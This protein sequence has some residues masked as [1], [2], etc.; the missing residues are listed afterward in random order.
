MFKK[1]LAEL[2]TS[3]PLRGS[4]RR[5][6]RQRVLQSYPNL[7]PEEGDALVPDGLQSQKF[8]THLDD[9]GVAYLSPDG[10]PLWFTIGKGSED[11]IP[12][13]YTLWKR[14]DLLPF[15]S[16]PAP[17]VPKLIGGADL[18]IPGVIQHS[19]TL[20]P[21]QVVS[22]TQ[23][24]RDAIG[25]P[26]AVGRMAVSSDTLRSE[27]EEDVKGK[28]VYILH[29]WK[30]ALWEMGPSK[31]ADPPAPIENKSSEAETPDERQ[32]GSPGSLEETAGAPP[33][34]PSPDGTSAQDA[35]PPA[36]ADAP[37][38]ADES[39]E[40]KATS[41]S[42]ED[43][44][45]CLR[46]AVLHTI[47]MRLANVPPSTFPIPASTFW[48]SHVLPARPAAA[49]GPNGLADA[50]WIDVKHSTH[51]NVKS[52]LKACAKEGLIKLKETKGDVVITAVSP[53]H[54]AVLAM[55]RHRTIGD[56]EA[57]AKKAGDREQKEKEAEEKRKSEIRVSEF[58][59]PF[60]TTVPF[61]VAA[62]KD[63]SEL[64]TITEI[65]DIVNN[66]ISSRSLVNANDP[67]Y[68]NVDSDQFLAGAV[69]VKGQDTP[70]FL[71]RDEVLKRIRA[72]MQTW[73]EISVEGRDT[74][75]KKGDLKPV[76][77][78]VK[79]RQ[80]RKACTL[81]TGYETFGLQADDLA[82]ELRKTCASSTS[83]SPVHGKP[84]SLEVMV[85][86]KQIKAVTDLLISRGV[87]ER[88]IEAEDQT[89]GK[90]K[91]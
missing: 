12:T 52:F 23:Y 46:A 41:L 68:I 83:V 63:T 21:D 48:S 90:K 50:S 58:W 89:K 82:E 55:R 45:A 86:G 9:P 34:Q 35:Q 36:T 43:V 87:P 60:G 73:H 17:V 3:A 31:K 56:L 80:G 76:S 44:S 57:K 32:N 81:I 29:T 6:L 27:E 75:R 64:Y 11:L 84:N 74:I 59:K 42:P 53:Q 49:L 5:K 1:P 33:A 65:K 91:K 8:S 54:P 19:S 15:L 72:H 66:Y 71:K 85:Q 40:S 2:K 39:A 25:P 70:E 13:V 7:P 37:T 14:P 61:F 16:T 78:V 88:W 30:D 38:D 18:M 24:Y 79:I 28:A 22:V 69:S 26:L 62:E 67:Q 20:V 4:D 10:D 47:G 77:V 51:K